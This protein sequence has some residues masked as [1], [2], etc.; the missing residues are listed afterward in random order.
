MMFMAV[1]LLVVVA[2]SAVAVPP[3]TVTVPA[4]GK[5]YFASPNY[6]QNYPKGVLVE[7]NVTGPVDFSLLMSQF[8]VVEFRLCDIH[9]GYGCFADYVNFTETVNRRDISL[10]GDQGMPSG[11]CGTINSPLRLASRTNSVIVR[12]VTGTRGPSYQGFNI[13]ATALARVETRIKVPVTGKVFITSPNFPVANYFVNRDTIYFVEGPAGVRLEFNTVAF[14]V[15]ALDIF[16]GLH[17]F[18]TIAE[19]SV[20]SSSMELIGGRPFYDTQ[21]PNQLRSRHNYVI[22]VFKSDDFLTLRGFNIS[23]ESVH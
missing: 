2:A 3:I 19:S 22:I 13:S 18:V 15:Q 12:F 21:G 1:L 9:C 11:M 6:P 16:G 5:A 17:D 4:T 23:A 10:T 8:D 7:Y 20:G 14:D